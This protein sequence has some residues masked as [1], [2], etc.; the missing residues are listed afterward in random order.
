MPRQLQTTT[1]KVPALDLSNQL[2]TLA[3]HTELNN[4]LAEHTQKNIQDRTIQLSEMNQLNNQLRE[5][6]FSQ[7][8]TV[9]Q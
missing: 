3:Y 2:K 7:Q 9:K 5:E 1:P 8:E 6:V 4:T